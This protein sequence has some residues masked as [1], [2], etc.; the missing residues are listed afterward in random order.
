MG[1]KRCIKADYQP[2]DNPKFICK[3]CD[4]LGKKEEQLCN[5]KKIKK[6][7]HNE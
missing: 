7:H 3:D 2:P 6:K 5:P 4:R 1:K